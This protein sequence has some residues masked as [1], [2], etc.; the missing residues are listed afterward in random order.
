MSDRYLAPKG[1][2]STRASQSWWRRL[3]TMT[4]AGAVLG[5][6]GTLLFSSARP[7]TAET[8]AAGREM[9]LHEWQSNDLSASNRDPLVA[10]TGDGLGPVFNATSCVACHFQGGVGGAGQNKQNVLSFDVVATRT[11]PK[12]HGGV[13]HAAA[14]GDRNLETPAEVNTLFPIV[15]GEQRRVAGCTITIPDFNPVSFVPINPPSLFG[16]GQ[17]ERISERAIRSNQRS[18][19]L[20]LYPR[21]VRGDFAG[22]PAGR[23]RVLPNGRVGKFGWKAQFATLEEFVA[24]ACAVEIGLS[25]PQRKQDRPHQQGEDKE[26]AL[27]MTGEQIVALTAYTGSLAA[28]HPVLPGDSAGRAAA[29][30]GEEL[31]ASIGC[32]DCHTPQLDGIAGIYSDLLLHKLEEDRD[33]NAGYGRLNPDLPI[34]AD[35]P[36]PNEWKTPAL[37]GVADSAPYFHDGG[38]PTLEAAI[39]RH[40]MQAGHVTERY[41][42]L[43]PADQLAIVGFLKTL[44]A[45][46]AE[47]A[48]RAVEL[49]NR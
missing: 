4:A 6:A 23:L 43:E 1:H 40:G 29:A 34:P 32:A 12:F 8:L 2:L 24:S 22:T 41:R 15:Q 16:S 44:R 45:P 10:P 5:W 9:F 39:L 36:H 33:I 20:A 27:D 48:P 30:R 11:N 25:N 31:F 35:Q 19:Q 49:V 46:Q 17:I 14:V 21:E 13:V 7:A 3:V 28:P 38:S 26:A 18:R 37:W 42:R 47:P